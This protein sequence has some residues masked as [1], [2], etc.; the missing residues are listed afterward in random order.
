M[1][2][3]AILRS[4][5]LW[6]LRWCKELALLEENQANRSV[7]DTAVVPSRT[8]EFVLFVVGGLWALAARA[9]ADHAADGFA[10]RLHLEAFEPSMA[11]VFL[12]F[13]LLVG[14]AAIH[15]VVTRRGTVRGLNALP[16]RATAGREWGMGAALGWGLVVL[17]VLPMA[18]AGALHP[19]FTWQA[20]GAMVVS[21]V[22]LLVLTL[23][24]ELVFRGYLFGRLVKAVGPTGAAL[25]MS[26]IAAGVSWFH[27][28]AGPWSVVVVFL[29]NLMFCMGYLRTHGIWLP[30][31]LHFAWS[32][33]TGVLFGLPVGWNTFAS[34]VNTNAYGPFWLTGGL[35]GP[36]GALF[37]AVVAV[38]G[39]GVLY[40][41]TRELAWSYTHP[42]IVAAGYAMEVTPPAEHVKMEQAAKPAPLVQILAVTP[43]AA[44]T[45]QA[46]EEHL[47]GNAEGEL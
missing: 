22:M 14:F 42:V 35:F 24:Q 5:I 31:G 6:R 33:C 41:M 18:L 7:V 29:L 38:V 8:M 32:A 30:W 9:A 23:A 27:P 44:S 1:G 17:A 4:F 3:S 36:E 46:I 34:V 39:M 21:V 40:R 16:A 2:S 45:M 26:A 11:A 12:V 19:V 15:W 25:L 10:V 47:R 28:L 20:A 37:T 43:S 13:L